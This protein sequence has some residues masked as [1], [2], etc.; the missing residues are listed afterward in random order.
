LYRRRFQRP[1]LVLLAA[2]LTPFIEHALNNALAASH[3]SSFVTEL[4]LTLTF[5][6]LASSILLIAGLSYAVYFERR[7]LGIGRIHLGELRPEEWLRLSAPEA[8]RR[9][10]A[11]ARAQHALAPTVSLT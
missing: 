3:H 9:G 10:R 1:G 2:C 8:Q 11:L 7:A 6:G 5:G 4:G